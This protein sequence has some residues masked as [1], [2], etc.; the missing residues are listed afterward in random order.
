MWV[1]LVDREHPEMNSWT[2]SLGTY[3]SAVGSAVE[4]S[5]AKV[6]EP[7]YLDES[8]T[9][10]MMGLI[11]IRRINQ[12]R[13]I[14]RKLD[15]DGLA[16]LSQFLNMVN[17]GAHLEPYAPLYLKSLVPLATTALA[18]LLSIFLVKWDRLPPLG[19]Y[20]LKWAYEAVVSIVY[21]RLGIEAA[22][23]AGLIM[24]ICKANLWYYLH[25]AKTD[26]R[27][28]MSKTG[29]FFG[30]V[31]Q[32]IT[33]FVVWPSVL[34][35]VL[36]GMREVADGGY[37]ELMLAGREEVEARGWLCWMK[38][39]EKVAPLRNTMKED[40]WFCNSTE[41]PL[42]PMKGS[43]NRLHI[44]VETVKYRRC[45]GCLTAMYCSRACQKFDWKAGHRQVCSVWS[46][47]LKAGDCVYSHGDECFLSDLAFTYL[48]EDSSSN[49]ELRRAIQAYVPSS[50]ESRS[51]KP[52]WDKVPRKW[53]M[54]PRPMIVVLD[55]N[56]LTMSGWTAQA[57]EPDELFSGHSNMEG[58]LLEIL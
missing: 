36:K 26:S 13:K 6:E 15:K 56:R 39:K 40:V 54:D 5:G 20:E 24:T 34:R 31:L 42:K 3:G 58:Q 43:A 50:I 46:Q 45:F 30:Q 52:G 53:R 17:K 29:W 33:R 21:G 19:S 51:P 49:E 57:L 25:E 18:K 55:G 48:Y 14:V 27:G 4:A 7:S 32:T 38:L 23:D 2:M 9:E 8:L 28:V 22:L 11:F 35:R 10:H 37:E 16:E 41:C 44:D 47:Q 12:A 1:R